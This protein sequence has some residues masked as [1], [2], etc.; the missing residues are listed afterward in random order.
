MTI[1]K[2]PGS[3]YYIDAKRNTP[4]ANS[5]AI[6]MLLSPGKHNI[7]VSKKYVDNEIPINDRD[8]AAGNEYWIRVDISAGAFGAHSRLYL[9]P[10][11]QAQSESKRMEEIRIGDVPMEW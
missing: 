6:R 7:S 1:Y 8:I 10:C 11:D 2:Q 4:I 3:P 9:V 5:Q